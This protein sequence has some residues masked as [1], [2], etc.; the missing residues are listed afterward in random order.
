MN[1]PPAQLSRLAR[2]WQRGADESCL[3]RAFARIADSELRH[4]NAITLLRDAQEN[5]PA[6]LAAIRSARTAIYFENF[7]V[8]DDGTGR[9]F[10]DALIE[11]A[12]A[13]VRVRVL[14]DWLGSS[15][16]ALTHMWSRPTRA[17]TQLTGCTPSPLRGPFCFPSTQPKLMTV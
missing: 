3:E 15:G 17:G 14:Y 11:R 2:H 4:G 7:I 9:E 5:Y 10:A 6:W 16:R 8:A 1:T 13:G 12:Q